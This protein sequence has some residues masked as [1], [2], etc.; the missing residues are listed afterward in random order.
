MRYFKTLRFPAVTFI[1]YCLAVPFADILSFSAEGF[2][3]ALTRYFA[4]TAAVFLGFYTF[5]NRKRI[6]FSA[7]MLFWGCFFLWALLCNLWSMNQE[8]SIRVYLIYVRYFI[9]YLAVSLFSFS[10]DEI[11]IIKNFIILSGIATCIFLVLKR[12]E[13]ELIR[14]TITGDLESDSVHIA[15]SLI[16]PISF[17]FVEIIHGNIIKK[18]FGVICVSL[19]L[20]IIFWTGSRGGLF[21]IFASLACLL[22]FNR[23]IFK[24]FFV[25]TV[26]SVLFFWVFEKIKQR[27]EILAQRFIFSGDFGRFSTG[28]IDIWLDGLKQW[29]NNPF[30]GY[31][32]GNFALISGVSMFS[33]NIYLQSLVELGLP[34]LLFLILA[35]FSGLKFSQRS[36]LGYGSFAATIGIMVMAFTISILNTNYFWLVII[37]NEVL[38]KSDAENQQD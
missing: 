21:G 22:I 5:L 8:N 9:F 15:G 38:N 3:G 35:L 17:L 14:V 23:Q 6:A 12:S 31:G 27:S 29:Q 20:Y 30:L 1:V 10:K 26:L 4:I 16:L 24:R 25:L 32:L 7:S 37:M 34:G 36:I 2:G 13:S 28:R 19:F 33:H 11:R 18:I